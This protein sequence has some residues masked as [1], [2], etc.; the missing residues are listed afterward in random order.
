VNVTPLLRKSAILAY[1]GVRT[2]FALVESR[3][4]EDSKV[5]TGL[6]AALQTVDSS[7]QNLLHKPAAD[8]GARSPGGP[9]PAEQPSPWADPDAEREAIAEA[10][11]ERQADV[12]E[13]ADPD[14][15]VA[16]VQAQLQAK[17]ALEEREEAQ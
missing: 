17:H 4:P 5:R 2:P 13:L 12:G 7:V 16:D 10:V 6:H 11:R 14:L 3:L 9:R 15:D 8:S 1:A